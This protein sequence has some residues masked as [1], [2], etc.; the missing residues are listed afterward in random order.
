MP[1]PLCSYA[2]SENA[3]IIRPPSLRVSYAFG[4]TSASLL[5][6]STKTLHLFSSTLINRPSSLC[7]CPVPEY[8]CLIWRWWDAPKTTCT[9]SQLFNCHRLGYVMF[10]I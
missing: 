1:V 8:L 9:A 4:Q 10:L 7:L 2:S 6:L 3:Q 5:P